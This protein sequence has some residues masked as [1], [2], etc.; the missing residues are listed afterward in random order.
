MSIERCTPRNINVAESTTKPASN[1]MPPP[2]DATRRTERTARQA[3]MF[4][5]K[6]FENKQELFQ[7]MRLYA[8][9]SFQLNL[10]QVA[11]VS[12]HRISNFGSLI[13]RYAPRWMGPD[14]AARR[15]KDWMEAAGDSGR[16][17]F[18]QVEF[19]ADGVELPARF[20]L[21]QVVKET[22][23][24]FLN[25]SS[26]KGLT[27]EQLDRNWLDLVDEGLDTR[28]AE[29]NYNGTSRWEDA[30]RA[31]N[32]AKLQERLQQQGY[33]STEIDALEDMLSRQAAVYD[34]ALGIAQANR[35]DIE[36][37]KGRYHPR[38]YTPEMR[39]IMRKHKLE[40]MG[41]SPNNTRYFSSMSDRLFT[42]ET[43][44]WGVN[45]ELLLADAIYG[46]KIWEK[47]GVPNMQQPP[48]QLIRDLE[49]K[50]RQYEAYHEKLTN[51]PKGRTDAQQAAMESRFEKM[52]DELFELESTVSSAK[53]A[54]H[55]ALQEHILDDRTLTWDFVQM[56]QDELDKLVDSGVVGKLPLST[57]RVLEVLVERYQLPDF[58][59][60]DVGRAV[61]TDPVR[62]FNM[63]KDSMAQVMG[64][65]MLVN[66][67]HVNGVASGFAVTKDMVAEDP[68]KYRSWRPLGTLMEKYNIPST[69]EAAKGMYLNEYA[70]N[71]LDALFSAG[72]EPAWGGA[73]GRAWRDFLSYWKTGILANVE[74]VFKNSLETTL[75]GW[76]AGTNVAL[77]PTAMQYMRDLMRFGPDAL[78]N[79]KVFGNGKYSVRDLFES[80]ISTGELELR[81]PF[82]GE[83]LRTGVSGSDDYQR[84]RNMAGYG[85]GVQFRYELTGRIQYLAAQL[86]QGD[87]L[88]AMRYAGGS[89]VDAQKQ[90][91]QNVAMPLAFYTD[92]MK[93]A[94][95]LT[96]MDTSRW[97]RV[98][99][100]FTGAPLNRYENIDEAKKHLN[101]Y[102]IRYDRG[103]IMD[104]AVAQA[105]PFWNYFS[106]S[107]PA[108]FRNI[109]EN[110]GQHLAYQRL[111][112]AV[113]GDSREDEDFT[114]AA[115]QPWF[116]NQMPIV[117]RDPNGR[118]NMWFS[119][120]M[121]RLDPHMDLMRRLS[122]TTLNIQRARYLFSGGEGVHGGR[123]DQAI[124]DARGEK[125]LGFFQSVQDQFSSP[126]LQ[127][128]EAIATGSNPFTKKEFQ[129]TE[130]LLGFEI[131]PVGN[132]SGGF[133]KFV[134]M[135]VAPQLNYIER[136]LKAQ[137]V[138]PSTESAAN[139][140]STREYVNAAGELDVRPEVQSA[141]VRAL[142]G[143]GLAPQLID[144]YRNL[145]RT[146][147]SLERTARDI[148][149]QANE[150][151]NQSRKESD[152]GRRM[153][154][155]TEA[156]KLRALAI[157]VLAMKDMVDWELESSGQLTDAERKKLLYSET[158][159]AA[160]RE[161]EEMTGEPADRRRRRSSGPVTPL[162]PPMQ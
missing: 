102:F 112:A 67:I 42:R 62:S 100:F 71:Q 11:S 5:L 129:D 158:T 84:L 3:E 12:G 82:T 154:L 32:Q 108:S 18:D 56:H 99:Q 49:K 109:M 48:K 162:P 16:H 143:L 131:G 68:A 111:Y 130:R 92:S 50:Y 134:V 13:S 29:V 120:D 8:Q 145:Q 88:G 161:Y 152:E 9:R 139:F 43:F 95:L 58:I 34:G 86:Q 128:Y 37:L 140:G 83:R 116:G 14:A 64:D 53:V 114:E 38:Y 45:D 31:R 136:Q 104:K 40:E 155:N 2:T 10:A 54:A 125:D 66:E 115:T 121:S 93:V 85:P 28:G 113:N 47:L 122:Q 81:A 20:Q 150:L 24:E 142:A 17:L 149:A 153:E 159:E 87:V 127:L 41:M 27:R 4:N 25:I 76:R 36:A 79:D 26:G 135:T 44:E 90:L 63:Y 61:I 55:G 98:G 30:R 6:G 69:K 33:T 91:F 75:Q 107:I 96:T 124:A 144:G 138:L 39:D 133:T 123:F 57:T 101:E 1:D 77:I 65:S 51:R 151:L 73:F 156:A 118:D 35:V 89:L 59:A 74:F 23:A 137:G 132:I 147:V 103:G 15:L 160:N 60:K 110:P 7:F 105:I 117:F 72:T 157:Q 78:P 70:F 119:V 106:T 141:F 80:A 46:D 97:G 22:H 21:S 19:W 52:S 94:N 146:E 126:I 148:N